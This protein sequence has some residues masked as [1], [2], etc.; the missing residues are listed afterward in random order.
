MCQTLYFEKHYM[1]SASPMKVDITHG[2]YHVMQNALEK[3]QVG[4]TSLGILYAL[5]LE[6]EYRAAIWLGEL[7]IGCSQIAE[8]FPRDV[9]L[10]EINGVIG[11]NI[12]NAAEISSQFHFFLDGDEVY[13]VFTE[14]DLAAALFMALQRLHDVLPQVLLST[15][16]LLY[17]LSLEEGEVGN[18]LRSRNLTPDR[19]FDQICRLENVD[20]SEPEIISVSWDDINEKSENR[21]PDTSEQSKKTRLNAE[22]ATI[23]RILDASA[24]RAMEAARVLEDYARFGLD[25]EP[26]VKTI[27]QMRHDLAFALRKLPHEARFASRDT[28]ADVGTSI[29][30]TGEYRRT[31]LADVLGANF[32]RLQ[33]SLRSL[34]E[35]GKLASRSTLARTAEQLRYQSY[36]LQK[37]MLITQDMTGNIDQTASRMSPI[38][39]EL[40]KRLEEACLYVLID[41]RDTEAGFVELAQA[42][43]SGGADVIQLRDKKADD[44]LLLQRARLLRDLTAG[45]STLMIVNDRPDLAV[46]CA[47]DGV[48]VG[49]EELPPREVRKLIGLAKNMLIG[50]S[51]H[52]LEQAVQALADGA[53]YIG[54]GPVFPS[55]TKQFDAFPGIDFLKQIA[56][57]ISLPAFAIGGIGPENLQQVIDA[58]VRRI[59]VQSVV[60]ESPDPAVTCRELKKALPRQL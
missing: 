10:E 53:D 46:L 6:E 20:V 1:I 44:L 33:E 9:S 13:F 59:A 37:S 55:T 39:P 25:D 17:V 36:T 29:E 42:V 19:I 54:V 12:Q 2:V 40:K 56:A 49:Q 21:D 50:V 5:L 3:Q 35:Y 7:G 4:I 38:L 26:L 22:S 52:S 34:E 14:P 58:G 30:G 11:G 47:A 24:N 31:S 16:H 57:N 28:L 8:K 27:K 45:T 23:Y 18:F 32:S 43:I 60:T 15:E 51:T 41:C 48:H